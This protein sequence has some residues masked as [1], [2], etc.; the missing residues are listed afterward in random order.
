MTL[1]HNWWALVLR[2]L[3]AVVFGLLAFFKPIT[4][5]SALVALVGIY[6]LF[7]GAFA[8][9]SAFGAMDHHE[10]W[11]F[12]LFEGIA[13]VAAGIALFIWPQRSA[14]ALLYLIAFWAIFTGI[15]QMSSAARW[16]GTPFGGW[17][18]GIGGALSV[19][20][21]ILL[22]AFPGA[23]ALSVVWLIGVYALLFGLLNIG[24]GIQ[25]RALNQQQSAP[26]RPKPARA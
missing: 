11:G 16:R 20:F 2:G 18:I 5:L 24:L 10:H 13:A 23:G 21:G 6:L 15:A 8:T 12:L 17:G 25:L 19:L 7:I 1:S 3:A 9:V 4:T 26:R 22:V 14:L